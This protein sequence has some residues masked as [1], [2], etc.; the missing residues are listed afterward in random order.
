MSN[1]KLTAF[2]PI[3]TLT[4]PAATGLAAQATTS[5]FGALADGTPIRAVELSNRNGMSA[6][7]IT[8][9]ATLQ[10]LVVPDAGGERADVVLGYDEPQQYLDEPQFFGATVGRYANR[11]AHGRFK[12]DGET[13][14]LPVND[15]QNHLHGGPR[16]LDKVVW[17]LAEA[18]SGSPARAVLTY[19]SPDGDMGYPGRLEITAIYS[20]DDDNALAIEYRARTDAP[21]IV[22]VTNHSYFN[23][24]GATGDES[25]MD[26]LLTLHADRFTPVDATLIPTGEKRPVAGTPFDF[27]TVKP[28]GRDIREGEDEQLAFGRGYDHNYIVNGT[29]GELRPA[30]RLE[31]PASGRAME[32]L[33][34]APGVQFYSG[35]FLD[36]TTIGKGGRIYRQG[37]AL[38][39]EPQV[40][41]DSPNRPKFP[42]A[43]LDPGETYTN[44]MVLR[45]STVE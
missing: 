7:V 21:T 38:C 13:Y 18:E 8:L 2:I 37:D 24:G 30:A 39:L 36:G 23:L 6:R 27:R 25:V 19:V 32:L 29:P 35:N 45:F 22:N 33:V 14:Q 11:I 28:I 5:D 1:Q 31:D 9:G 43:R 4:F 26:H 17:T 3:F 42:S 16:G 44:T 20:L 10:A 41:P 34:T 15:G 12:L 40:F